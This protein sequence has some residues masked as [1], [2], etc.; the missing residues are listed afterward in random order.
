[1]WRAV[2][3]GRASRRKAHAAT[4]ALATDFLAA[5]IGRLLFTDFPQHFIPWPIVAL[6]RSRGLEEG[7]QRAMALVPGRPLE[8][9][10]SEFY[11][12]CP[13]LPLLNA[14][15]AD[16]GQRAILTH[17]DTSKFVDTYVPERTAAAQGMASSLDRQSMAGLMHHSARFPL[18]SPAGSVV[19]LTKTNWLGRPRIIAR[20]VDG[21]YFDNSG[22]VTAL[23]TIQMMPNVRPVTLIVI[24]ND[25]YAECNTRDGMYCEASC[26]AIEPRT[27]APFALLHETLPLFSGL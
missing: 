27:V 14:T 22:I 18:I 3:S 5:A 11:V 12:N 26:N 1:M 23:E 17:L 10:A 24:A 2:S 16:T 21:G 20:L 13:A 4:R 25:P 8:L 15:V 7:W 6:N 9:N 19:D